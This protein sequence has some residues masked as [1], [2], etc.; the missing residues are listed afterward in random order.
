VLKVSVIVPV[1]NPGRH[2]DDCIASLLGQTLPHDQYELIFVDDGSTDGSGPRL[3]ELAVMHPN[4]RVEHIPNSGWPGKPRN[5]GLDMARGEFVYFVDNDDRI[6]RDALER[7]YRTALQEDADI[8]IG[9][10]VGVRRGVPRELFER[11]RSG[12]DLGWPPLLSLLTPHKLFRRHFVERHGIRFPDEPRRL[13]DHYFVVH[14]YLHAPRITVLADAPVYYWVHRGEE[15]NASATFEA[16]KYFE[17]MRGV[18][19]IVNAHVEP[20]PERDRLLMHW[21][22]GKMLGRVGGPGFPKRDYDFRGELLTEVRKVANERYGPWVDAYL[23]L[24]LRV[25]SHVMLEGDRDEVERLAAFEEEVR[26]RAW[27]HELKPHLGDLRLRFT[28]ALRTG[29]GGLHFEPRGDRIYWAP[30]EALWLRVDDETLDVTDEVAHASAEVFLRSLDDDG[31]EYLVPGHVRARIAPFAATRDYVRMVVEG[32]MRL[33]AVT[34]AAGAQL[35]PG[36]WDVRVRVSVAGFAATA[37][38]RREK[39]G[40]PLVV[41][42]DDKGRLYERPDPEAEPP[43][44][45]P[46]PNGTA[47]FK[48]AAAA[49]RARIAA[50]AS[51]R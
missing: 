30:P 24:N 50:A 49:A 25:R 45:P 37:R 3:D 9:K 48:Q 26:A 10:V 29:S 32:D 41:V 44:P 2:I 36:E 47:R 18:L 7:L 27:L 15:G 5:V 20:G 17:D 6:A 39:N 31:V 38:L 16:R 4:V 33:T 34:G 1:Y 13:E 14:A 35:P 22:R 11:N 21:Y 12:V 19:D 40:E 46:S 51:R 28:S 23:P 43:P 42:S 8:V